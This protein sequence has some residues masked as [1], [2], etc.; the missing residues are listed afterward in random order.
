LV[1]IQR[2]PDP[3]TPGE[4]TVFRL[5][6]ARNLTQETLE[7]WNGAEWVED[8]TTTYLYSTRCHLD[9]L[10]TPDGAIT[11]FSYDCNGNLERTWDGNHPSNLQ[12]AEPSA[13]YVYL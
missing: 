7:R 4:R 12:M 13:T 1:T 2:K 9:Q 8:S 11:E 3:A 10:L 5:D 6:A